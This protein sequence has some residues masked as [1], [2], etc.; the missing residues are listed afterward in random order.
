MSLIIPNFKDCQ[1]KALA[2]LPEVVLAQMLQSDHNQHVQLAFLQQSYTL[3]RDL[4]ETGLQNVPYWNAFDDIQQVKDRN[5]LPLTIYDFSLSDGTEPIFNNGNNQIWLYQNNKLKM[6]V[7]LHNQIEIEQ[8]THFLDDGC[9]RID[10]YDDRGFLSTS[11]WLTHEKEMSKMK[12]F[13]PF[14]EAVA[15]MNAKNKVTISTHFRKFFK[16]I[17]MLMLIN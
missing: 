1:D 5:G 4:Q 7:Q 11:K 12:W 17:A 2:D 9:I 6:E 10:N 14:H 16:K 13:T 3:N 8:V 15:E